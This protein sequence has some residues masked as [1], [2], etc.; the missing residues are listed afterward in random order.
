MILQ[1]LK[2]HISPWVL[3]FVRSTVTCYDMRAVLLLHG[4][5]CS[6][7]VRTD[8]PAERGAARED[9]AAGGAGHGGGVQGP[10]RQLP[11]QHH[12]RHHQRGQDPHAHGLCGQA[13]PAPHGH[14]HPRHLSRLRRGHRVRR[15]HRVSTIVSSVFQYHLVHDT[16]VLA[17]GYV[18]AIIV[19]LLFV[20]GAILELF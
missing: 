13:R 1:V 16:S 12:R 4:T 14:V 18:S 6:P 9:R 15:P 8:L 20:S 2:Q 7:F 3:Y 10:L 11:L 19:V 5:P 17:S